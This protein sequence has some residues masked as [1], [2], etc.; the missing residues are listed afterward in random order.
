MS[1][2]D[3]TT[4]RS[5]NSSERP[6]GTTI[7]MIIMHDGEG[8]KR[9]DLATLCDATVPLRKRVSAHYYI[10]RAG[11][12]YELVHPSLAA[13]HA[14]VSSWL[15]RDS[16]AIQAHSIGIESEHKLG[17]NWPDVQRQAY[18]DLCRYLITRYHIPQQYIAAHS[19]V[20]PGRKFDPTDWPDA[21][22]R[23]WIA[24]LYAETL[25][26]LRAAT[27][28]SPAGVAPHRCSQTLYDFYVARGALGALGYALMDEAVAFGTDGRL[29]S[30]LTCERVIL[31][32]APEGPHYALIAEAKMQGWI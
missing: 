26:P 10:D 24:A 20:A 16:L 6:A 21:E 4:Y 12:I 5:P 3:T 22:L 31:K 30:Y 13:W 14:G 1:T 23:L 15:G 25:D 18:A 32:N 17:Q 11:R 9:S 27:L 2:I 7:D 28:P 29:C 19:W 8:T